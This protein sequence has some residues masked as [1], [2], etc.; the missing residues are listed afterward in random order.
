MCGRAGLSILAFSWNARTLTI[1]VPVKMAAFLP[2]RS[3]CSGALGPVTWSDEWLNWELLWVI[4]ANAMVHRPLVAGAAS[5][6]LARG[7]G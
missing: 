5:H 1:R 3:P 4:V 7:G 2:V 6:A